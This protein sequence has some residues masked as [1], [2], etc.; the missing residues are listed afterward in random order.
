MLIQQ[1]LER[2]HLSDAQQQALDYIFSQRQKIKE[3]NIT[4]VARASYT[5]TATIVRLA[6]KLGFVG[7]EELKNSYLQEVE[8]MDSHFDKMNPN[9]PF[10]KDEPIQRIAAKITNLSIETAQDT[11]KLVQHDSLQKAVQTLYRAKNIHLAAISYSLLLGQ[12]FRLDMMRIGRNVN[13]CDINGEELFMENVIQKDD[14]VLFI[15]YSGEIEKLCLLARRVKEKGAKVITITSIGDNTL[16]KY[17]DV[18][19]EVS[20]REKLYSKIKGYSNENSIKLVLDILYSC[21]FQM[22]YEN[23]R[24][25]RLHISASSEVGRT[26][27]VDILKEA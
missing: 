14:C 17:S 20:T 11:L 2:V 27:E 19:L 3:M 8:Y 7:Y 22:E 1:K 9:F 24:E 10:E 13:V 26:S 6:K 18:I 5:S 15:S 21:F 23:N 16:K 12:I 4:D 25:K